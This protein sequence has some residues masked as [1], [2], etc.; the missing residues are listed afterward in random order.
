MISYYKLKKIEKKLEEAQKLDQSGQ[1][2]EKLRKIGKKFVLYTF[3]HK[4]IHKKL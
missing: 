1:K 4:K 2:W 3:W